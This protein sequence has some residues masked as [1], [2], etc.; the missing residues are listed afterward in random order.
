MGS[1]AKLLSQTRLAGSPRLSWRCGA[2]LVASARVRPA[3]KASPCPASPL[4]ERPSPAPH[5]PLPSRP[6][7]PRIA[8]AQLALWSFFDGDYGEAV[9]NAQNAHKVWVSVGAAH[10]F[11]C[12]SLVPAPM[13]MLLLLLMRRRQR[14]RRL[15]L[16][17][18]L[19]MIQC[20]W[21]TARRPLRCLWHFCPVIASHAAVS[22]LAR[23]SNRVEEKGR[24]A[25]RPLC[26]LS[27]FCPIIASHEPLVA[28]HPCTAHRS[29]K[30]GRTA[31]RPCS[32]ASA[33]AWRS[34]VGP[35]L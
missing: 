33:S 28:S 1:A 2:S 8:A 14:R 32:T 19:L 10:H 13:R 29:R 25:M 9:E 11:R 4:P 34:Q 6:S 18:L 31:R 7:L 27:M 5:L 35:H 12:C 3:Q 22:L 23:A 15:P 16:P 17:L 30:W 21:G 26:C 24:T 20:C